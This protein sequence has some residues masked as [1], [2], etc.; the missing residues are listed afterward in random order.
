MMITSEVHQSDVPSGDLRVSRFLFVPPEDWSLCRSSR[1]AGPGNTRL[2][3]TL[4]HSS[5]TPLDGVGEQLWNSSFLLCD[6]LLHMR[7]VFGDF[8]LFELGGGVGLVAVIASLV[9][10]KEVFCTD[11][12]D[13]VL[14]LAKENLERNAHLFTTL[15]KAASPIHF[16]IFDWMQPEH[17]RNGRPSSTAW[18][19][20]D[21]EALSGPC[22]FLAADV[23]YDD[24]LTESLF[25]ALKS[26][27]RVDERVYLA[28]EKRYNFTIA[29]LRL[30]A[31]GYDAFLSHFRSDDDYSDGK[32]FIGRKISL[33]FPQRFISY[34]RTH[35]MEL[36]ELTRVAL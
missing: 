8:T 7:A 30:V 10:E 29:D 18:K 6:F 9:S 31:N 23:I 5:R 35:D 11:Y 3:I 34:E 13:S 17:P 14:R 27:V 20:E 1:R 24:E 4:R 15:N 25:E 26:V 16:R 36:W 33:D 2:A 19:S 22:L 28:L 21:T 12:Q 32:L